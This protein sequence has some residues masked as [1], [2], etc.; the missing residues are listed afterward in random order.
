MIKQLSL[1]LTSIT[2]INLYDF[3]ST[4]VNAYYEYVPSL[5]LHFALR[6]RPVCLEAFSETWHLDCVK[7]DQARLAIARGL[8]LRIFLVDQL[9]ILSVKA[10]P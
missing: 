8:P 5:G 4:P 1:R 6:K 2:L 7:I 10:H 9:G 3:Q